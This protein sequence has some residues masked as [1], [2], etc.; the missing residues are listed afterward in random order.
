MPIGRVPTRVA[1]GVLLI[2]F[3][4]M[5]VVANTLT[6]GPIVQTADGNFL[7]RYHRCTKVVRGWPFAFRTQFPEG[8]V[9]PGEWLAW[10][11]DPIFETHSSLSFAGNVAWIS[12]FGI[13]GISLILKSASARPS[14]NQPLQ[15]PGPAERSL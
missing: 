6:R 3:S 10:D 2:G 15:R 12:A 14:Q 1:V 8:Y 9:N 11:I 5:C 4:V 7:A 13:G